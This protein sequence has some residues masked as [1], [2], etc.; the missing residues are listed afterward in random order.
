MNELYA[1]VIEW[2]RCA[3]EKPRLEVGRVEVVG[4]VN[5]LFAV[6]LHSASACMKLLVWGVAC[7]LSVG[8]GSDA[9][10]REYGQVSGTVTMDGKPLTTGKVIFQHVEGPSLD[11]PINPDGTYSQNIPVGDTKIAIHCREPDIVEGGV[12][13]EVV[14]GK[15]IV[16]IKYATA[17]MTPLKYNVIPGESKFDIKL[18]S[19]N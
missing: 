12:R 2:R 17:E 9:P 6:R 15:S 11:A 10:Q 18:S 14:P 13:K 4:Q 7:A 1:Q 16:P 3:V 8:C 19:A 5:R